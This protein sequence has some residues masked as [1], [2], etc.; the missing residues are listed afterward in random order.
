MMTTDTSLASQIKATMNE[1]M[2]GASDEVKE[3]SAQAFAEIF[4]KNPA[5]GA[6]GTGAK[7]PDFTLPE[8]VSGGSVNLE[9]AL[10]VGPVVL[11]FYRGGWCPFCNLEFRALSQAQPEFKALGARLI[12]ISPETPDASL[13]TVR[14]KQ[15]DFDVLSDVGNIVARQYGLLMDV[16][17]VYRP[18]YLEMGLDVPAAN[19]DDTWELPLPATYVVDADG[20]IRGGF[21][22]NDYTKRMEP[23]DIVRVLQSLR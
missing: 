16:P 1:I 6:L 9:Q 21:L 19:G 5:A 3:I 12:G 15:I 13:A 18:V 2:S 17:E 14:E 20:T 4:E 8:V 23:S 11:S 10:S 7:A 22:D